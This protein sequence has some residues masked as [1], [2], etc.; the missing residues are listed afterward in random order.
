MCQTMALVAV[1]V[2]GANLGATFQAVVMTAVLA[3]FLYLLVAFN[4]FAYR[5]T[6]RSMLFGVQCLLF[7]TF[8]GHTFQLTSSTAN[9]RALPQLQAEGQQAAAAATYGLVMGV[10]LLVVN[11]AYVGSVLWQLV[12][13]M[14]WQAVREALLKSSRSVELWM[15]K[16]LCM[17]YGASQRAK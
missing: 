2:F 3:V 11:L 12:Q 16:Q 9:F 14:E 17:R 13:L 15:R 6:G 1:S 5:R 10:L 4:P 8:V 7:T